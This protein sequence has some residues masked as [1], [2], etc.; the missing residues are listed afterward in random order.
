[1]TFTLR[2]AI[3]ADEKDI[4]AMIRGARLNPLG[5]DW[6]RFIVAEANGE[7]IG[8]VQ[9]KPHDDGTR[10]L[11]SLAVISAWQRHGVGTALVRAAVA[12]ETGPL[13]LTCRSELEGYYVRFGFRALTRDEMPAYFQRLARL[14]GVIGVLARPFAGDV[15]LSVMLRET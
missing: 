12:R 10:E 13:Y 5:L 7:I 8:T 3:V 6:R 15:R 1:V 11:A 14:V 4:K 2:T 9:V